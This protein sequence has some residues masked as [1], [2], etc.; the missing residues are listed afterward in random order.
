MTKNLLGSKDPDG[1]YIVKAPQSLANIIVKRYRG[2]IELIEMG[3]EIIVR[4]KSRRV[5]LGIIK[6][7]ERK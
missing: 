7:L 6:M 1:Y 4:T 2:Q 3:D 5:A